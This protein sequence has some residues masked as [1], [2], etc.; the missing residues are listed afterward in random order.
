MDRVI[1]HCDCNSFYASVELLSHP[2]LRDKP[3]AVGGDSES[4]HGIILAKNEA[5]KKYKVQTA[6]TIW[7]AKKKCP[8][9][10]LLPPHHEQYAKYSKIINGIYTE[11]TD[12]VEPFGIDESWLDVS[13]SY[14]MFARTPFEFA[15][16][17]RKR[18]KEETGLTVSIGVS[19]N[20]IFAKLGSDYKKPDAVTEINRDNYKDIVYP[21]PIQDMIYVG[22]T[23]QKSLNDIGIFTI[24]QLARMSQELLENMFGKHGTDLYRSANGLDDSPVTNYYDE[25]EIKSVGSGSTFAK[26]LSEMGEIKPALMSLSEDVGARLRKNKMYANG[27]QLRIKY[28]DFRVIQRQTKIHSTDVTAEIYDT[29]VKLF[30]ENADLSEGIR[31]LTVTAID[32]SKEKTGVQTSL[33]DDVTDADKKRDKREKLQSTIDGIRMK[34]GAD[35]LK[36]ATVIKSDVAKRPKTDSYKK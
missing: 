27:V 29:A 7:Q 33:F 34:F 36:S 14:M 25:K 24:G 2:E 3:V 11:Y 13:S 28:P 18:V 22:K 1:L 8:D 30:G 12:L 20:K 19:F 10:I 32:L 23:T 9:L 35:S 26:N 6:E 4:R 16:I 31:A 17:I 5:A 21:L 15:Q